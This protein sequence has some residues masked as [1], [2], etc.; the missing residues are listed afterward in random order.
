MVNH[1]SL[2][3]SALIVVI[4]SVPRATLRLPWATIWQA[5]PPKADQ[6]SAGSLH[7]RL[8]IVAPNVFIRFLDFGS[9]HL[10]GGCAKSEHFPWEEMRQRRRDTVCKPRRGRPPVHHGQRILDDMVTIN[11]KG[12]EDAQLCARR[13]DRNGGRPTS[14][15]RWFRGWLAE[16]EQALSELGAKAAHG[17]TGSRRRAVPFES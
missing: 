15:L 10:G 16:S 2:A 17:R 12:H 9:P 8:S 11:G 14:V 13:Q 5:F 1:L 6:P 4:V 3:L 7:V